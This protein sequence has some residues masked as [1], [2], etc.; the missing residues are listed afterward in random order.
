MFYYAGH[1]VQA[2]GRNYL[3]PID[4]EIQSEAEV[5]DSGVDVGLVLNYMDEAQNGLNIVILDACRN[6]PFGRSFRSAA[7][8][9]AQVD[10]PTGTLIAYATAPGRVASDGTG[11]NGLYTSELL[12]QMRV[13]SVSVTDMFMRVRAE[14]M[15][16]TGNKQ[17][18][19]ESSSLVGAFYFNGSAGSSAATGVNEKSSGPPPI[20]GTAI[21]LSYWDSI[22]NS[23]NPE[24]FSA[25]LRKYPN[26]EFA[27]LAK[28]RLANFSKASDVRKSDAS[29]EDRG[30]I[31]IQ[32][33][34]RDQRGLIRSVDPKGPAAQ[35]GLKPDDIIMKVDGQSTSGMSQEKIISSIRGP[36]GTPVT[37]TIV[38]DGTSRDIVI[39]RGRTPSIAAG[40]I[41]EV[42]RQLQIKTLWVESEAKYREAINLDPT[43]AW[44]YG[45]M[46]FTLYRQ[47]RQAE[48]EAALRRS[49][50]LDPKIGRYH[51]LVALVLY[52]GV[53]TKAETSAY[54][55]A[56]AEAKL[57]LELDPKDAWHHNMLGLVLLAEKQWAAAEAEFAE[58]VR[59]APDVAEYK[60]NI[61]KAQKHQRY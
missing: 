59:L 50:Q 19:W 40:D 22:K 46:G 53:N 21:E 32:F 12:K 60:T 9:L 44:Y 47:N 1:G 57:A 36:V 18:P 61:G 42:A 20:S 58:A 56:H 41:A 13:P 14:V 35:A 28:I 4:A 3:I 43:V 29:P 51:S 30:G 34:Y 17:V 49:V 6:N 54:A 26:G 37:L 27:D 8:G 10:A 33:D 52:N 5:E 23:S 48:A 39:T 24:D 11:Q 45:E 25:Y 16:Q 38:R 7:E 31:G 55:E 15:K 2:K